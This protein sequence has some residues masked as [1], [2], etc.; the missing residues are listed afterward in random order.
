MSRRSF[1]DILLNSEF[2]PADEYYSLVH[3]LYDSDSPDHY[4]FYSLM[5]MYFGAMPF[6][7]TAISLWD[8]NQRHHFMFSTDD[9]LSTVDLNRILLL[10]EYILNFAKQMQNIDVCMQ[11]SLFFIRRIRAVCD[12]ISY[13]EVEIKG[14]FAL[15]PR[16]DLINAA[17]ECSP[18]EVSIDLIT[19]D[20]W[21]YKGDLERKRQ[22]LSKF[23]RELEP[24]RE[25]LESL[26]KRLTS[27]FF[28]LVNSLNIR[29]NN[30]AEDSKKY[31]EPLGSMSDHELE[32]WYDTLRNM[33]A[34]LFLLDDYSGFAESISKLKQK[35]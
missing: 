28:Y 21:R 34:S 22:Y 7:D 14:I 31:F 25:R 24:K 16:N 20:Y 18:A 2:N 32:S 13:Q 10:C 29:H 33:A 30:A 19:F 11:D 5:N 3:L 17:A 35:Q 9:D 27:D 1:A 12:K 15:V 23:A 8:F 26:S 4:S 6:A